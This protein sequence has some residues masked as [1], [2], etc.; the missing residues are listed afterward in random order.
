VVKDISN[1]IYD[2]NGLKSL[3]TSKTTFKMCGNDL[4]DVEI[5]EVVAVLKTPKVEKT[6][7]QYIRYVFPHEVDVFET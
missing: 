7:G 5:D 6:R 3:D 1:D 2:M 4:F